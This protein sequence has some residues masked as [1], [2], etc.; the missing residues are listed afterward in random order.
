HPGP[1][2]EGRVRIVASLLLYV[3]ALSRPPL[4]NRR[5]SEPLLP[6]KIPESPESCGKSEADFSQMCIRQTPEPAALTS[7][8]GAI[9]AVS[10]NFYRP[11][12][13]LAGR[14]GQLSNWH[15]AAT[16]SSGSPDGP[17]DIN[18]ASHST[19]VRAKPRP[20]WHVLCPSH[21]AG[22]TRRFI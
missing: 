22:R 17:L 11:L 3:V 4:N 14:A 12:P 10:R 7:R 18:L 13:E 16:K 20:T 6:V 15:L 2:S 19:F 8:N 21:S 9:D 5:S 1:L